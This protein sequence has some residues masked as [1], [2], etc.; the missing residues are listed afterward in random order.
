MSEDLVVRLE[1]GLEWI[2]ELASDTVVDGRVQTFSGTPDDVLIVTL[3]DLVGDEVEA[4]TM[5]LID[6]GNEDR[7]RFWAHDVTVF[8]LLSVVI[9]LQKVSVFLVFSRNGFFQTI[10]FRISLKPHFF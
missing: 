3:L 7:V 5:S 1:L 9:L 8:T 10:C 4:G 2:V 6:V